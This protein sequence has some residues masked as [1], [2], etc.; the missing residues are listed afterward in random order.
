MPH[1][2]QQATTADPSVSA[3]D[4]ATQIRAQVNAQ[5]KQAGVEQQRAQSAPEQAAQQAT[6][7]GGK[8]DQVTVITKNGKTITIHTPVAPTAPIAPIAP[9]EGIDIEQNAPVVAG[10]STTIPDNQPLDIPPR[11]ENLGYALF[12]MLAIIAIG[13]P[14]IRI[15]G[16]VIERRA[17]KPALP[18][19]FGGRLERIEQGIEAVS[20]EIERISES[21][22]YL[23]KVQSPAAERV[24]LPRSAS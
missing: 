1:L 13:K 14:I 16:N 21:Q 12:L 23:L 20:I 4:L 10:S 2:P 22:R 3:N 5:L 19:D 18:A 9:I 6:R 17:S 8:N 15:I 11:V 7:A 24:E